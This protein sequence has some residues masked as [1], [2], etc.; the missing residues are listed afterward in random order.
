[1]TRTTGGLQNLAAELNMP[2]VTLYGWMRRGR[3]DARRVSGQ[4]VITAD[5]EERRRL[6]LRREQSDTRH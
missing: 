2:L 4:W 5:R 1:M 6:R 3:L